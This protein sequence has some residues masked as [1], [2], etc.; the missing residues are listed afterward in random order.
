MSAHVR[1]RP[2]FREKYYLVIGGEEG[3]EA[4]L[5]EALLPALDC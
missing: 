3:A 1:Y 2:S 5:E 4:D